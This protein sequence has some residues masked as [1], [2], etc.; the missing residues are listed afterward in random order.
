[1]M[2]MMMMMMMMTMLMM[3]TSAQVVETLVNV[4]KNSLLMDYTHQDYHTSTTYDMTP[5][6]KP[7]TLNWRT[8]SILQSILVAQIV[9][10]LRTQAVAVTVKVV[11][12]SFLLPMHDPS[13]FS[14]Y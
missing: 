6:V 11:E 14:N 5:R 1:M 13:L 4:T 7:F 10:P 3:M 2:M 8:G 12:H 9:L